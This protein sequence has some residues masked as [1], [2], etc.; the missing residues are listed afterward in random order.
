MPRVLG[1]YNSEYKEPRN[2]LQSLGG[3]PFSY[4]HD[5]DYIFNEV[6]E[7]GSTNVFQDFRVVYLVNLSTSV[8]IIDSAILSVSLEH[9]YQQEKATMPHLTKIFMRLF[10]PPYAST[11]FVHPPINTNGVF[12]NNTMSIPKVIKESANKRTYSNR[13]LMP[14]EIHTGEFFPVVLHRFLSGP[15]PYLRNYRFTLNALYAVE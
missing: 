10:I 13:V 15:L 11:N 1:F 7:F 5:N 9:S 12:K 14:V 6:P 4:I 2:N 8:S 3:R